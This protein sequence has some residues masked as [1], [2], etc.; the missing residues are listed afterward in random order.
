[1]QLFDYMTPAQILDH[2]MK[3]VIPGDFTNPF[4]SVTISRIAAIRKRHWRKTRIS[5]NDADAVRMMIQSDDFPM[6]SCSDKNLQQIS[7]PGLSQHDPFGKFHI[8][9]T[10]QCQALMLKKFG[11]LVF[12]DTVHGMTKYGYYNM[13]ILVMDEFGHG[14]PVAFMLSAHE[15]CA[16]W[17][18][19]IKSVFEVRMLYGT[20][21]IQSADALL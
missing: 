18:F 19:F 12:L 8:A 9:I 17:T 5:E 14:F 1:V 4:A 6:L 3:D 13:A 20:P 10:S 11:D 15:T 21:T 16:D 7:Q 2:L